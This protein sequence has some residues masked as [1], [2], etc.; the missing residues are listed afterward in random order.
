MMAWLLGLI[1]WGVSLTPQ[2][3]TQNSVLARSMPVCILS[4]PPCSSFSRL[5][6][7]TDVDDDD[8][9]DDDAHEALFG[10][11]RVQH[12]NTDVELQQSTSGSE[13]LQICQSFSEQLES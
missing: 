1:R 5:S 12:D 7:F 9:D 11:P 4:F 2:E 6:Q 13:L 8:D 10:I 3:V